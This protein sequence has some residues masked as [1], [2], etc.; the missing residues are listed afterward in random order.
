[1]QELFQSDQFGSVSALEFNAFMQNLRNESF[2]Y[3]LDQTVEVP[4]DEIDRMARFEA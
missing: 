3:Q 4:S 2:F 1:M